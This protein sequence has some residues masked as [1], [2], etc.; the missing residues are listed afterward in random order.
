ML[1]MVR[2]SRLQFDKQLNDKGKNMNKIYENYAKV[3]VEYSLSLNKGEKVLINSSFLAK[4]FLKELY[5]QILRAG[6]H[7]E[8]KIS[9]PGIEKIFYDT[10]SDEQLEYISP[11]QKLIMD[12]YDAIL[13]IRS[14]YNVKELQ[15]VSAEKYANL[16]IPVPPLKEQQEIVKYLDDKTLKI[17]KLISK[18]TKAI[19]LLKE[20]RTALISSAVTGKID[21]RE[22]A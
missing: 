3:L 19:D 22:R 1:L 13:N 6:A 21:V 12:T 8:L 2:I 4:D 11:S 15:N 7:P 16:N 20:K 18:S 10:A 14:P 17:D 9:V 5:K